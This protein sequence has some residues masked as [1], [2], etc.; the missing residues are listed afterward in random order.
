[1]VK[2]LA[3]MEKE[4]SEHR[5]K[6]LRRRERWEIVQSLMS[7]YGLVEYIISL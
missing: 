2:E 6:W 7:I 5:T 3:K 1:M 4:V